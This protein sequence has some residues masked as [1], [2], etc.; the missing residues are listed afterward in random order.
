MENDL[1]PE[2]EI[3]KEIEKSHIEIQPSSYDY[4]SISKVINEKTKEELNSKI[5][6]ME[7]RIKEQYP[8][9]SG[10]VIEGLS[11]LMDDIDPKEKQERLQIYYNS[12][13]QEVIRFIQTHSGMS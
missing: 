3:N 2:T 9:L 6:E 8:E 11:E 5:L 10:Y 4:S 13:N 1:R 7:T 12:L